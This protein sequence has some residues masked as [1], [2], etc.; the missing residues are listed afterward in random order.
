M[1]N[2]DKAPNGEGTTVI[3]TPFGTITRRNFIK[4]AATTAAATATGIA[5]AG[6]SSGSSGSSG[7]SSMA[8]SSTPTSAD[9]PGDGWFPSMCNMCFNHCSILGHVVDGKLVEIKGDDRSPAGWGHLCGKGTAGIMQL[10]DPNR[11]T[12]PL[13]RTNPEKGIGIDPQWEEITWDEAYDEIL[14]KLDE[15]KEAKRPVIVFALITSIISWIDSMTFLGS[16]GNIPLPLKADI[17]GAPTHPITSLL[18][19]C[20]NACPDYAHVKYLMQFGTQAGVATRHGTSIDGKFFAESRAEGCKLVVFDPHMSASGEQADEWVPI[21]PGTDAA[22]ALA[23]ANLLVNE[24]DLYDKDFL[25]NR[26]NAP[27]LVNISTGRI[28]RD[29]QSNKALFWDTADNM[30]K[31]Y[32]TCTSPALEGTYTVDG[33]EAR[34][35]FSCFKEHVSRYTPEYAEEITTVP[36]DTTRRI[37]REFGEAACIGQ[38]VEVDGLTVPYRPVAVDTFSGIAR[39]KHGFISHW[40]ILQLNTL[41][42]SI[43]ARGGYLGYYTANNYGFY[44][45]DTNHNWGFSVWEEDGLIEYQNM[46]HGWPAQSS[47][48]ERIRSGSY[49]PTSEAMEELQPFTMD[50]HFAYISQLDP[51]LYH[52]TPSKVAFCMAS[53]PIKNWCDNAYQAK[54]LESFDYIYGMDIYL[55]ESSYY[56]DLIIPEP[57][58]LERYDPLPLSFNNHRVPGLPE[59][60]FIVGTRQPIVAPKDDCPSALD[61]FGALAEK[62]GTTAEFAAALNDYYRIADEYKLPADKQ[63]TAKEV[64][65]AACQSLAGPGHDLDW[66]RENGIWTRDRKADEVYVFA[67]GKPGRIPLYFDMMLEAKEK[68]QEE[69]DK[70][71]IY[72]ETDDYIPLPDW[73]PCLDHDVEHEGY[74]LFPVYWTNAIN[75]D[76]WQVENAWINEINE[77]DDISYF[78]EINTSTG[79]KYGIKTGDKV[80]LSSYDGNTVEGVAVLTGGVHPEVVAAMGGHL[81]SQSSYTPIGEGKGYAI[82]HL[83]PANDPKRME[84]VGS[85]IDQCVRCKIEKIG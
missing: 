80:R 21:R 83:I 60:P 85:G 72:W 78:L 56:Y 11:I 5:L 82:N 64:C 38:T 25:T 37:A 65:N 23:M 13:R 34:T 36:A 54:L 43:F 58:Y 33:V 50:Q 4:G 84:Y 59:V 71:G 77:N 29:A 68:I 28:V 15:E 32:D 75:T 45:G 20:G 74:E 61:T 70:L 9:A 26:T 12:V 16:R 49:E 17:C 53:N 7:S 62:G 41:V 6:C 81:N 76:T 22:V 19:G 73:M 35:A 8:G 51:D 66:F 10:Y 42:G 24:Y 46:A 40:A 31:P 67:A 18:T 2:K 79:E 52:T 57:S 63:I 1:D 30:A 48:Y 69:V 27:A 44:D 39:H 47:Y 55:N 14:S 3:H